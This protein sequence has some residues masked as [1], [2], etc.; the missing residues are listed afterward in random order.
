VL[1]AASCCPPLKQPLVG[2]RLIDNLTKAGTIGGCEALIG[3][4]T[5]LDPAGVDRGE[6]HLF[7]KTRHG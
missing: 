2:L 6:R 5:C 3:V 7:H 1:K 4:R